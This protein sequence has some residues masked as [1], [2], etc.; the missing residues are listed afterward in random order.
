LPPM[1]NRLPP[2]TA[3]AIPVRVDSIDALGAQV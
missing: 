1:T 3:L 2:A